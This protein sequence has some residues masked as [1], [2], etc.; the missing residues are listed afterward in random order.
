MTHEPSL[1]NL[2]D[3]LPEHVYASWIGALTDLRESSTPALVNEHQ[4]FCT[5]YLQ[6][7]EDVQA[8]DPHMARMLHADVQV[9]SVAVRTLLNARLS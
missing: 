6:A 8:I 4:Q 9:L 5:A 2:P 7:L 3:D 1:L